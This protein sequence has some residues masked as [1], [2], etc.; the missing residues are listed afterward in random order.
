MPNNSL[1][2]NNE[3]VNIPKNNQNKNHHN[4]KNIDLADIPDSCLI[5]VKIVL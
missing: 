3:S 5:N 1:H 2:N 4:H